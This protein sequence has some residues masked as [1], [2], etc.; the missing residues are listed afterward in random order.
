MDIEELKRSARQFLGIKEELGAL[1]DR[2][3][4]LKKR[5]TQEID[6]LEPDDKGHR[7]FKFE[8]PMLGNIKVTKQRKV[9]KTLDMDVAEKILTDKG[10]KNTCIK[11]IPTLDEA[12]IMAAF[13][14]GYLTEEDIDAMFP[15]KETFAFIVDNK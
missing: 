4:A 15:A 12:A 6:E 7:V 10:I 5:M 13:Y 3:S 11:M 2:Q 14:E 8:D 1:T 9:S